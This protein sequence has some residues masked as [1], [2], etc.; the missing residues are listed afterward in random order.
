MTTTDTAP[1][2]RQPPADIDAEA[3]I[4][5]ACMISPTAIDTAAEH[6][7]PADFY[8][9]AHTDL[10][11]AILD[12]RERG[13]EVDPITIAAHLGDRLHKLGGAPWLADLYGGVPTAANAAYYVEI[14]ADKSVR[15]RLLAASQR[16]HQLAHHGDGD[17]AD[18]VER[19]R[20]SLDDV[21]QHARSGDAAVDAIDLADNALTRYA[22]EAAPALS[23]GWADLDLLMTGGLRPGNLI[24]VGARPGIGKSVVG[25]NIPLAA[26]LR[27]HGALIASLEMTEAELTDRLLANL[28]TIEL[29]RLIQHR[30][31]E[32]DWD[33]VETAAN[34]LRALPLAVTDDPSLGL[35]Q[36]RSH[37]RDRARGS[38][39]LD[40][41]V[42]DYLGLIRPAD[43]RVPRQEQVSAISRGLKLLAKELRIPILALHQLNRGPEQRS[44]RRPVLSDLRESGAIEQDA[45]A[46]WLLHR[47]DDDASRYEIEINVAKNRQG[48]QGT[49]ILPWSPQFARIG[50]APAVDNHGYAA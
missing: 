11:A 28:G 25:C 32:R 36:I 14:V 21:A 38:T 16:V 2:N 35:A 3:A 12:M 29:T 19:A 18:V 37:A 10:F 26:A 13:L 8:R 42:V 43:T 27:G 40:L 6:I 49:V 17:T 39:G 5:G 45:D 23:T 4:L 22:S 31:S 50:E 33:A 20:Q 30:L 48:R 24:V 15:R 41:L 9:P 44:N 47:E 7:G 34:R 1:D 46:V